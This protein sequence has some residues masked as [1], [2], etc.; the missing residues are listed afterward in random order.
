MRKLT[1]PF[2]FLARVQLEE[3]AHSVGH[4]P[5]VDP[6]IY[7]HGPLLGC[8]PHDKA[9]RFP[10][11]FPFNVTL[12]RTQAE[13]SDTGLDLKYSLYQHAHTCANARVNTKKLY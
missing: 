9:A 5:V 7:Q 12:S 4:A 2:S 13:E 10:L 3:R 1:L 11:V 8:A 6:L